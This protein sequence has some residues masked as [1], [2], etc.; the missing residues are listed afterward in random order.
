MRLFFKLNVMKQENIKTL[1]WSFEAHVNTL[2]NWVEF[3]LARDLQHLLWY[4]KWDNFINVIS[5]TK[6]ATEISWWDI[7]NHFADTGKT[8]KMPKGEQKEMKIENEISNE[9]ITN[10][11][12]VRKTLKE[13]WITLEKLNPEEDLSKV[14]RKLNSQTKKWLKSNDWFEK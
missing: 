7:S 14:E 3:W 11:R 1:T 10:N 13:R 12:T 8:I 4:S 2:D 9:H 6:T 5:K